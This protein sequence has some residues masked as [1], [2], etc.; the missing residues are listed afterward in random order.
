MA[1]SPRRRFRYA[2]RPLA[3][4]LQKFKQ[5]RPRGPLLPGRALNPRLQ[6][7]LRRANHLLAVGAHANAGR[8]FADMA[9]RAL[10]HDIW[11]PAPMLFLQAAHAYLLGED[12]TSSLGYAQRGLELLASQQRAAELRHA[13]ARYLNELDASASASESAALRTWLDTALQQTAQAPS[14]PAPGSLCPYCGAHGS[15]EALAAR[16]GQAQLC[17]YCDSIWHNEAA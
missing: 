3:E 5:Q 6:K 15:L 12:S 16:G 14:T 4:R 7:E 11:Y 8:I 1:N 17:R 9:S 10:D 2:R 13:A